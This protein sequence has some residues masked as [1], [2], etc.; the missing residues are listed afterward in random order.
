MVTRLALGAPE[1]AFAL[2][3][4][5]VALLPFVP[6]GSAPRKVT[7]VIDDATLCDKVAVTLTLVRA[8]GVN[9]RQISAV[10]SCT[11][12][13]RTKVQVNPAPVTLRTVTPLLMPS[14]AMNANRSSF[15]EVVEKVF[16]VTEE[17]AVFRSPKA[18]VSMLRPIEVVKLSPATSASVT[19]TVWLAG[20][21]V[22]PALLGVTV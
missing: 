6:D 3:V 12:V 7:T 15:V 2:A 22:I 20:M 4:A 21:K 1:L 8:D 13:R 17:L 16:V 10:P 9:A 18:T 19:V 5:P 11:F 14:L